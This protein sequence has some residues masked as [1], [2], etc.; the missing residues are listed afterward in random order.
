MPS[1]TRSKSILLGL[2][3]HQPGIFFPSKMTKCYVLS[4]P[5]LSSHCLLSLTCRGQRSP[6]MLCMT[7]ARAPLPCA[8]D[9][10]VTGR[11][12][13]TCQNYRNPSVDC[14]GTARK[15]V[16]V[17]KQITLTPWNPSHLDTANF[18]QGIIC[19]ICA[20]LLLTLLCFFSSSRSKNGVTGE[21]RAFTPASNV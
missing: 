9:G 13:K 15:S 19:G 11:V 14:V 6:V 16:M 1:Y 4:R 18:F 3:C 20:L 17:Q 5:V 7:P 8:G 2:K 10:K 12:S 21:E